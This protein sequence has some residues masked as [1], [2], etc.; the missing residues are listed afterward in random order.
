MRNHS[1]LCC[2]VL[3]CTVRFFLVMCLRVCVVGGMGP[4]DYR[5]GE[6]VQWLQ[7]RY[8]EWADLLPEDE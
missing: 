8:G 7:D 6:V 4:N 2:A 1:S 5:I 3:C